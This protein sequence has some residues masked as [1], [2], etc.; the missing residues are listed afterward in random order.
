MS[1]IIETNFNDEGRQDF[2]TYSAEVLLDRA[3][4][5]AEDGLLS[6]QR[7]IL[8]TMKEYL[9]MNNSSKTKKCNSIV[10]STLMTSYI[11]GDQ[12]CYGVLVK[13]AQPFL[14]RYPLITGQGALGTQESND[15]VAS[16]RYTEAK[17]SAYA[18]L[19]FKDFDKGIV[20]TKKTYNDEFDEP[21]VLPSIFP[22]A[23]VNGKQ[24]I[25]VGLAHNSQP[26]NLTEVCNGIIAYIN[27]NNITVKELMEYIPGP[28]YPLGNVVINKKDIQRAFETG[29]SDRGLKVRGDY[30]VEKNKII[31][32]SIPYRTYRNKI[33]EQIKNNIEEFE[34]VI[35]DFDDESNLGQNK[36]IF[37]LKP[38]VNIQ[39]ALNKIFNLTDLQSSIS[40]N[41]NYLVNGTPKLCSLKDLIKAYVEHQLNII[42]KTAEYDK[43]KAEARKHIID[44]LIIATGDID[45]AIN[46]IRSSEDKAEAVIKLTQNF[47][48]DEIQAK[49]ILDMRLSKLTKLD[50]K[51]L[52]D[53]LKEKINIINEANELI[54]NEE[55]RN[56][57]LIT[58][59]NELKNKYGDERKTKLEDIADVPKEDKE[60]A[61]VDPE[62][63]VVVMT[64]AGSIKRIP[65][66]SFKTQNRGGK[67]IKTQDEITNAVIRTNT[68]DSLMI[69]SNKGNMYRLLVNDVP[70]GTNASKGTPI[71]A[72]VSMEAG[73]E[74]AVMYSI[75]RDTNAE[76]VIF[77]TKNGIVK[78]TK[79]SEYVETKKKTGLKAINIR[80]GDEL[81]AVSLIKDEPLLIITANG[82]MIKVKSEEFGASGRITMGLK[83]ITLKPNDYVVAALPIRHAED[84]LAIFS[85]TGYGKRI[86]LDNVLSQSRGGKGISCFKASST[87]GNI[88]GAQLVSDED[89][90][91]II[92]DKSSI[93][94]SA[95]DIPYVI[96][97]D[98]IGN[99]LTKGGRVLSV[100]K[101]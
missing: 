99:I 88:A 21:V 54:H 65:T 97:K 33:K 23:L 74:P 53:E 10:G 96:S 3:I 40:Y 49:A 27:N 57:Y 46:L 26:M 48:V 101:V 63:C 79:L 64:E 47:I 24:T 86:S 20:P 58:K 98:S 68:I 51:E 67:G 81:A 18:D 4:P 5:S 6:S 69:F 90:V 34:K 28:D 8:W 39:T 35:T 38:G 78:K 37:T 95:K 2:L 61:N 14:M 59:I 15:M 91:L 45:K 72:L 62:K 12:A 11:H 52:E 77:I 56:Q 75:Y 13:M 50:K 71:K 31:F 80:E 42:V 43:S 25:A 87:S 32:T 60:I 100:S 84:K 93:C 76:Y 44:G 7:K 73:E 41:M 30:V 92:S 70:A 85:T 1:E 16:S 82:M 22:N 66:T 29:K 19:M 83:G 17:P 94:I 36:L 9:K 55:H 89:N